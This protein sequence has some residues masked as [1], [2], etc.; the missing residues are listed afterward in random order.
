MLKLDFLK[1]LS[2]N[3]SYLTIDIDIDEEH[4]YKSRL[5]KLIKTLIGMGIIEKITMPYLKQKSFEI[6]EKSKSDFQKNVKYFSRDLST[7]DE[8]FLNIEEFDDDDN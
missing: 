1:M 3:K 6:S 8:S 2:V 4:F 5:S 7:N